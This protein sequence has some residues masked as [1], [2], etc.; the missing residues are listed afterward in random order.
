MRVTWKNIRANYVDV[1]RSIEKCQRFINYLNNNINYKIKNNIDEKIKIPMANINNYYN[2]TTEISSINCLMTIQTAQAIEISSLFDYCREYLY[3]FVSIEIK[4][5]NNVDKGLILRYKRIDNF[6]Y[7]NVVYTFLEQNYKINIS[8]D[9]DIINKIN[10]LYRIGKDK[11]LLLLNDYKKKASY[12]SYNSQFKRNLKSKS[13]GY[14]IQINKQF[15]KLFKVS[16]SVKNPDHLKY[17]IHFLKTLFSLVIEKKVLELDNVDESNDID[18]LVE[19]VNS[20]LSSDNSDNLLSEIG[21][22][23]ESL[24]DDEDE[25]DVGIDLDYL[26]EL[27]PEI[28][29]QKNVFEE[30]EKNLKKWNCSY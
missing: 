6:K 29:E 9:I 22:D 13:D 25:D 18:K 30:S 7:E 4:K 16:M 21:D 19:S 10:E 26:K 23:H 14:H 1:E 11:A 15:N 12:E 27:T 2:L 5:E 8:R 17:I 28:I 3:N 24:S 20:S